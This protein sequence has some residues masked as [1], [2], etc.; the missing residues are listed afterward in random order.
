MV[1]MFYLNSIYFKPKF[2]MNLYFILIF[3][4]IKIMIIYI[5]I[6]IYIY[7]KGILFCRFL[8]IKIVKIV[9]SIHII[10]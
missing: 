5:Y 9:L 7:I 4:C 3:S 1:C 2:F 8:I 6:Y 10:I